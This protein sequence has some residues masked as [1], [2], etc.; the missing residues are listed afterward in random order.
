[1]EVKRL[2]NIIKKDSLLFY[3]NEYIAEAVFIY[4]GSKT[5]E[6]V[7]INFIIEKTAIGVPKISAKI[8]KHINYPMLGAGK[9]LKEYVEDLEKKG[10]LP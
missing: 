8:L 6:T 7:P 5:E 4:G 3:R 2:L 10:N 1:M 9:K